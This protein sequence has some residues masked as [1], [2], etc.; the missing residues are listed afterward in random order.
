MEPLRKY[1]ELKYETFTLINSLLLRISKSVIN[2]LE[3]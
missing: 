2:V 1:I 3:Y